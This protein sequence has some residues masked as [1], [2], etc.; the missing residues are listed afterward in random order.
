MA[1]GGISIRHLTESRWA[2]IFASH[3]HFESQLNFKNILFLESSQICT[4]VEDEYVLFLLPRR[5]SCR[6]LDVSI[7]QPF[8]SS[9]GVVGGQFAVTHLHLLVSCSP[10]FLTANR[11]TL[12]LQVSPSRVFDREFPIV[13]GLPAMANSFFCQ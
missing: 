5:D 13:A 11:V 6:A 10:Y 8:D 12:G 2:G 4:R 3:N 7:A 1:E 9:L